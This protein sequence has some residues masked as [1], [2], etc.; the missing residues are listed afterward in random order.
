M[1]LGAVDQLD[2]GAGGRR[3]SR[4]RGLRLHRRRLRRRRRRG[5]RLDV[6]RGGRGL[7]LRV[8]LWLRLRLRLWVG[9]WLRLRLRL[10]LWLRLGGG[11]LLDANEAD[12]GAARAELHERAGA[13]FGRLRDA[14]TVN[15]CAVAPPKV[16]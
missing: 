16:F 5:L 9:W 15:V 7:R 13:H 3:R 1:P 4:R 11:R 2:V 14:A 10:R 6:L 12:G 8:W